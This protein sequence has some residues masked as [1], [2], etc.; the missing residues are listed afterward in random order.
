MLKNKSIAFRLRLFIL[1]GIVVIF[2]A[3]MWINYRSS[4]EILM[5]TVRQNATNLAQSTIH[6]IEGVLLAAEKVPQ[7]LAPLL[8]NTQY[9]E[10]EL[11]NFLKP[12]VQHN[13]EIFG[14]CVAFEPFAYDRNKYFFAPYCYRDSDEILYKNLGGLEY[15]YFY[16]EWY[17]KPKELGKA[18]WTEPFYDEN[19]G[20]IVMTTYAKPFYRQQNDSIVFSGIVT[21]DIDLSWLSNVIDSL[22]I[23]RSGYAY[24]LSREGTFLSFPD[25][26]MIMTES[27]FSL[28]D[29]YNNDQLRRIGHEMVK[30]NSGFV[31]Y[32][33][34][35]MKGEAWVYYNHLPMSGWSIAIVYPEDELLA[36]L[37]YLFVTLVALALGGILLIFIVITVISNRITR[38]I[39]KLAKVTANF[40]LGNFDVQLPQIRR[41]DE[42]GQ[43]T[44]SFDVMRSELKKYIRNLEETTAAKN[45]IESEL[46][47]AHDIQ[48][49]IIP[50]IFPPFPERDDVD[51]YAV[52]D[53]A[54]EVGGDLYD[55]F[56]LDDK[57][58]VFAIGDVSGKGVPASLFMA[59][60]RTL[61]RAKAVGDISASEI[62]GQIN[63]ELCIDNDN[64][65]FVTFFLGIL[66]LENGEL[67]FCN[68]GHNYPYLLKAGKPPAPLDQTH[69]TPLGLFEDIKYKSGK[70]NIDKGDSLV[71]YTDG[72]PEAM[73]PD[74]N[75]FG[76]P[77]LSG[78]LKNF[79]GDHSP[80]MITKKLLEE[81]K[82]FENGASQAD[83]ITILVL[84]Y[85][86]NH[87]VNL[88]KKEFFLEIS[89][90]VAEI[91]R[92][93]ELIDRVCEEWKLDPANCHKIN[94][95]LQ[96]VVTNIINYSFPNGDK[97]SISIII[98]LVDGKVRVTVTDDGKEF[99][100]LEKE[101]PDV[102]DKSLEEREIGGLG[103]YF[104]KQF[105]DKVSY[106]RESGKNILTFEKNRKK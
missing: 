89:N 72:I 12:I 33:P 60:T 14:S 1:L 69:G 15:D 38:P 98:K 75:L 54:K 45:R 26:S 32:K 86:I 41:N 102:L 77:K 51:L 43:L 92:M 57:R 104:L 56:F 46:K 16:L 83:D 22:N 37:H 19:G 17:L 64:A 28:A 88:G 76:D 87:K 47:I 61:L 50:K 65:M 48:Q 90:D 94:L 34:I 59:I 63:K 66:N 53:P 9:N 44:G 73:D 82:I 24:L 85:Y 71:L 105:M 8:E 97:H 30:G 100:P 91:N 2:S 74:G 5:N 106:R 80:E 3:M 29:K 81:T 55:F 67:D 40:G 70:I 58:L 11:K 4:K 25:Q 42:I 84:T 35:D 49:G 27:I 93:N 52:L 21:V 13:N 62:V 79:D 10:E 6:N 7:N 103:I 36:D 96:E 31:R 23:I 68:A 78:I 20:N 99:N 39:E 18:V 95:A 101:D